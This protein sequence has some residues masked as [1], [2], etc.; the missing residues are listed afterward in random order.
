M[1]PLAACAVLAMTS[2]AASTAPAVPIVASVRAWR[3]GVDGTR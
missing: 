3:G 2:G 1:L